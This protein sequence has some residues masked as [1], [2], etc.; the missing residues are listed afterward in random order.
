MRETRLCNNN[1]KFIHGKRNPEDMQDLDTWA[2][3]GLPHS[4]GIPYFMENDFYVG[5]GAYVKTLEFSRKDMDRRILLEF[6]G[7]FQ[8]AEVFLNGKL[9]GIHEGG[10]TTFDFDLSGKI[11]EGQNQLFVRVNNLWNAQIAP[12]AGEHQFN[13]GIYRDVQLILSEKICVE[14]QGTFVKTESLNGDEAKI[15]IETTLCLDS[16]EGEITLESEI[17][18]SE[19]R[20]ALREEKV[21]APVHRQE[22]DLQGVHLWSPELPNLYRLISRIKVNNQVVDEYE[23][24]FGIRTVRFDKDE[25]FFL[26]G[27]HYDIH[28]ANVH[29]DHAGWADAVTRSGITRDI[30]MIKDCGMNFIRGS[31]Y[32]HHPFFAQECDRIGLLFWSELCYWG[33]GGPNEEGYWYSSAYPIHEEDQDPFEVNCMKT[34]EEMIQDNRNSPSVIIWSVSNEPFFSEESVMGKAKVLAKKLVEHCHQLDSSRVAAVGGAQRGGFDVLGDVAGYNGDG[35]SLFINPGFPSFV[36]EY[37]SRVSFRP[38]SFDAN[39]TDNVDTPYQWRSGK[40][41]WCAFH[42]GSI[43]A[44]MGAMGMI[45]YYRLPLN[46]WYW[47]REK[48]LGIPR[49][50]SRKPGVSHALI[51]KANTDVIAA[52]GQ[53][54]V[55]IIIDVVDASGTP[56]SNEHQVTLSIIKGDGIFPTGKSITFTPDNK[57]FL[58]GQCAIEFRSYY[59]GENILEATSEG[60]ESARILITAVGEPCNK[61]L[62]PISPPPYITPAPPIF[63]RFNLARNKPVFSSSNADGY[64]GEYVT[65]TDKS[66][67]KPKDR[68]NAWLRLDLEGTRTVHEIE[69]FFEAEHAVST[70]IVQLSDDSAAK[71]ELQLKWNGKAHSA[72]GKWNFRFIQVTLNEHQQ[73]VREIRLWVNQ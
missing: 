52:N 36:S 13:G 68:E 16:A 2:D 10:Y 14:R 57:S 54:D 22:F 56:L 69:V 47:Y 46:S 23:T 8:V 20:V 38:G 45:D 50:Q 62:V 15:S 41:L 5:Y 53:E 21:N 24:I 6:F 48:L 18:Y 70:C 31:H 33:T 58:Y 3:I 19:Q 43:I 63:E 29:Q 37:G 34:L 30:Q 7:V 67:W 59:G 72:K 17:Q 27:N 44:D 66:I 1:W 55:H 9:L 26:N 61:N 71:K 65:R 35:A 32:P 4:F 64:S 51:M 11:N 73:G 60:L 12:R 40:A 42:H 28:G 25:G 49:P 39:Y